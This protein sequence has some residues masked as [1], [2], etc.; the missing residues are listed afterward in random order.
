MYPTASWVHAQVLEADSL[1]VLNLR[2][3]GIGGHIPEDIDLLQKLIGTGDQ[4]EVQLDDIM[5]IC[6]YQFL[7]KHKGA[8]NLVLRSGNYKF[9]YF[10]REPVI[11]SEIEGEYYLQDENGINWKDY[12]AKGVRGTPEGDMNIEFRYEGPGMAAANGFNLRYLSVVPYNNQFKDFDGLNCDALTVGV[13]EEEVQESSADVFRIY[14]N[15]VSDLLRIESRNETIEKLCLYS[16]DGRQLMDKSVYSQE[17]Q[18]DMSESNPGMY[19]LQV[20]TRNGVESRVVV[21]Q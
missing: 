9:Y 2:G 19:I 5:D 12:L 15:P 1:T 18:L 17:A 11:F 3:V 6:D 14:P 16:M 13:K 21:K 7:Y 4:I 8:E 10:F 20:Y